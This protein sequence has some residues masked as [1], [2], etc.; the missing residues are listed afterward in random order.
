M[1]TGAT[2]MDTMIMGTDMDT[3]DTAIVMHPRLR[4]LSLK[5]VAIEEPGAALIELG[6]GTPGVAS[7]T[8]AGVRWI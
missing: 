8:V 1:A 6:E 4:K 7:A 3:M 2:G 5:H